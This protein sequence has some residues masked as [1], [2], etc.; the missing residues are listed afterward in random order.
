MRKEKTSVASAA[1][2]LSKWKLNA[3][4]DLRAVLSRSNSWRVSATDVYT[5][6]RLVRPLASLVV[7]E[8]VLLEGGVT[9][10]KK[11]QRGL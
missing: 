5:N 8:G 11:A 4:E 7:G 1:V 10:V 9:G 3:K 6:D 2:I